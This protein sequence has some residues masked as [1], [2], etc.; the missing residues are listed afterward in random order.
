MTIAVI[1]KPLAENL[2]EHAN[3]EKPVFR[4]KIASTNVTRDDAKTI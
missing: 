1:T 2:V 4:L 3:L